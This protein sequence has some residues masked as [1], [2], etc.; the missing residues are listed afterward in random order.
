MA[1]GVSPSEADLMDE[2]FPGF[3]EGDDF[4]QVSQRKKRKILV[5]SHYSPKGSN[6]KA[7]TAK[8]KN[9][10]QAQRHKEPEADTKC[11]IIRQDKK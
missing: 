2:D 8:G 1:E 11:L 3:Q 10:E 5:N 6:S 7:T 9:K 4:I